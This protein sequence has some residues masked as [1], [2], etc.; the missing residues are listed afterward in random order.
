MGHVF[1][2]QMSGGRPVDGG[3]F[4]YD[5]ANAEPVHLHVFRA[6][7]IDTHLHNLFMALIEFECFS[8]IDS[9]CHYPHCLIK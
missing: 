4:V 5:Y 3:W 2:M 1:N 8:R 7:L 9:K 6:P